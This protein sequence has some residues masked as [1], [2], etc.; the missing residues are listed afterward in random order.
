[1][2]SVTSS[3]TI[4]V[5]S[6]VSDLMTVERKRL[7]NLEAKETTAQTK[8][9]AYGQIQSALSTLQTAV[10]KLALTSSYT[11]TK[12]TVS[13][14][15]ATATVSGS[16]QSGTYS[17]SVTQLARAQSSASAAV[18]SSS[19]A[20][21]YG[22][23]TLRDAEGNV[24]TT[25]AIGSDGAEGT[26]ADARD[27]INAAGVGVRASI[28]SDGGQARL[29]LNATS[30][31]AANAFTI[32][33]DS[34]LTGLSFSETPTQ[35]ATDAV[36]SVNGLSLTSSSNT[37]S[38]AIDGV[39][40]VLSGEPASGSG[41]AVTSQITISTD[42]S[43]VVSA[44]SDFVSAYNQV[45]SLIASLSKYDATTQTA[46]TLNGESTLRSIQTQLRSVLRS[47]V[48]GADGDY[49]RLSEIG[50]TVQTDGKLSLDETKLTNAVTADAAKVGR[51]FT[52]TS[53][54]EGEKG[55]AVRMN[56]KISAMLTT[57]GALESRQSGLNATIRSL[58]KAQEREEARLTLVESR[59]TS[60]YAALDAL[61][62]T[63][64]SQMSALESALSSL[65][66]LR[67]SNN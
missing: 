1:M 65:E 61:L 55:L 66:S 51:L 35:Q 9:S 22:N 34:T 52:A 13:G 43:Q 47:A 26:L 31:G 30:T 24:L 33:T 3:S 37:V 10:K 4:D 60:Q 6:L 2:A 15:A 19:T 59:L 58:D 45:E 20:I 62:T 40:L 36:F 5:A 29:V 56:E 53:S 8:L 32:E 63:R 39:T 64:S 44:V 57:G 28:V 11:G 67:S 21:G 54:N 23:L 16:A 46:A 12:A 17:V 49:A 42:A 48:S 14:S 18:A 41:T 27:A 38:D 25:V 7:D 50:V